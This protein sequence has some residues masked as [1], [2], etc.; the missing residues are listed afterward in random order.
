VTRTPRDL[1]P[2][3]YIFRI[4]LFSLLAKNFIEKYESADFESGGYKWITSYR[5]FK[6]ALFPC[7][8]WRHDRTWYG[9]FAI[10]S[11]LSTLQFLDNTGTG[12]RRFH[13]MKT[14]WGFS[15]LIRLTTFNDP[16]H[17]YLIN[18]TC[19]FGAEVFVYKT[20]GK[21]E[22]L[23]MVKGAAVVSYTWKIE[24]F[25]HLKGKSG[26]S[27]TFIAGDLKWYVFV[28]YRTPVTF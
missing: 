28:S 13:G 20:S 1:P 22:S 27:G 17:G 12:F 16:F 9:I 8:L 11:I 18:D 15:Q 23:S 3:H 19:V 25:S 10:L 5:A 26:S 6:T 4:Q 7:Y 2:T 21:G 14:E 24:N